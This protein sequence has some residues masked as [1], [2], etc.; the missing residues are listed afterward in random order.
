MLRV[1]I[2][3]S[4]VTVFEDEDRMMNEKYAENFKVN[5]GSR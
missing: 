1:K 4:E 3:R 5:K 2:A